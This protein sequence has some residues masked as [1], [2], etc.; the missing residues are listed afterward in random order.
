VDWYLNSGAAGRF[1]GLLWGVEL[2]DGQAQV[3]SWHAD[4]FPEGPPQR[5]VW[6]ATGGEWR[7]LL[8]SRP[9]ALS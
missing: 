3:I 8:Q 6:R 7:H 4:P 2:R 9:E 5:L 1:E